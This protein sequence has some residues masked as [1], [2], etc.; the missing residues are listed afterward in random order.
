MIS[1]LYLPIYSIMRVHVHLE[2][3]RAV[4][5]RYHSEELHLWQLMP[6]DVINEPHVVPEGSG[7]YDAELS[8]SV[9]PCL[10]C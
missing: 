7:K 6:G 3:Q 10:E 4:M 8:R 5:D 1:L 2:F 9:E